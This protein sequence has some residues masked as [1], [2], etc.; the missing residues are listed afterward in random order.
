MSTWTRSGPKAEMNKLRESLLRLK[1]PRRHRVKTQDMDG[2]LMQI[3]MP[4]ALYCRGGKIGREDEED[5]RSS[6]TFSSEFNKEELY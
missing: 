3:R 4:A 6:D 2:D 5:G 1:R